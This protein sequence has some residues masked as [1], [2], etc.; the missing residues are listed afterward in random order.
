MKEKRWNHYLFWGLTAFFVLAAVVAVV[1]FFLHFDVCARFAAKIISI[2]KPV[3]YGAIMAYLMAPVYD[4]VRAC[5]ASGKLPEKKTRSVKDGRK[6]CACRERE[7]ASVAAAQSAAVSASA[8]AGSALSKAPS[9]R[10]D[11]LGKTAGTIVSVIVLC[12]VATGLISMMLPELYRSLMNVINALPESAARLSAWLSE[13]LSEESPYRNEIMVLYNNAVSIGEEFVNNVLRPN[14]TNIIGQTYTG[15]MS[16]ARGVYNLA[17]GLIVMIYLLNIKETLIPQCKKLIFTLFPTAWAERIVCELHYI[18]LVFGGFIIGKIVDSL[19]IGLMCFGILSLLNMIGLL[20]M[21]Y[22]LL[23]SVIVGV[24]N[25]I[26]FFGPFIG[27]IPSTILIA[28]SAP[29]QAVWFVLFVFLLQQFDGNFLGPKILGDKTGISSFWVLFSILLF[30]GLFGFVGMI[31]AVPTWA[32]LMNL[33]SQISKA[34][35]REKGLP[36]DLEYYGKK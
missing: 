30:G 9:K 11:A 14:I 7:A 21:P 19:I 8:A 34:V 10:R 26:P 36:D 15:V 29:L 3:I 20:Q 12:A 16:A 22:V 25:V 23:V 31:I 1:F 18:N 6:D 35:L 13:V 17:I 2:L 27:A 33:I 32:V 28:L 24:T 5:I 4:W